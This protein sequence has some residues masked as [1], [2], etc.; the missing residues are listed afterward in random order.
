MSHA[1]DVGLLATHSSR[2]GIVSPSFYSFHNQL[3]VDASFI[4]AL[5]IIELISSER[6]KFAPIEF[7][8]NLV[9]AARSIGMRTRLL[10]IAKLLVCFCLCS[11]VLF[12]FLVSIVLFLCLFCS[13]RFVSLYCIALYCIIIFFFF[14]FFFCNLKEQLE[15]NPARDTD[16]Q[17]ALSFSSESMNYALDTFALALWFFG[18]YYKNPVYCLSVA[19]KYGD[20]PHSGMLS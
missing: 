15:A 18:K 16:N 19:I 6:D 1:V 2:D 8:N 17:W 4:H 5:A 10:T 3:G 14:F 12:R 7:I 11:F 9:N 20:Q 13:F